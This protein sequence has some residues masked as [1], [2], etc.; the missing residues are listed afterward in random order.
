MHIVTMN[1]AITLIFTSE[2]KKYTSSPKQRFRQLQCLLQNQPV[3]ILGH[4]DAAQNV[5]GHTFCEEACP[6]AVLQTAYNTFVERP[7]FICF[8]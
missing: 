1:V 4:R 3:K 6:Q 7:H 8:F 2:N 5:M